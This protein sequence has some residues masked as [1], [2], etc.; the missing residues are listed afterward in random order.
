MGDALLELD[1]ELMQSTGLFITEGETLGLKGSAVHDKGS[2]EY[3]ADLAQNPPERVLFCHDAYGMPKEVILLTDS[4]ERI[5]AEYIYLYPPGIPLLVPG[6]KISQELLARLA[7]YLDKGLS[8]QGLEDV[9]GKYI[10]VVAVS[11]AKP[12]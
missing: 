10:K 5:A 1:K 3:E 9:D 12:I 8:L 11:G 2:A 6:E 4:E 7:G